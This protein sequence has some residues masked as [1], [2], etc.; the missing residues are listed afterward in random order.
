MWNN[1]RQARK[2][3]EIGNCQLERGFCEN[4]FEKEFLTGRSRCSWE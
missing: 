4:A 1:D 2:V 3:R